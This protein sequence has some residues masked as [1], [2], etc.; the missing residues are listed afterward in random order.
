MSDVQLDATQE[1]TN[2]KLCIL[3]Q[4]DAT[5]KGPMVQHPRIDSF[6]NLLQAV[7]ERA[8]LKDGS[9][10]EIQK[11]LRL[12]T[13]GDLSSHKAGWHRSCYSTA[14]NK[15][16]I[17]RARNRIEDALSSGSYITKKRGIKR[18]S[19]IDEASTSTSVFTRSSTIPL[20]KELC[21][22]CQTD[23]HNQQLFKLRTHNA[24]KA[25]RDALE[26]AQDTALLTRL[27]TS[28]SPCD[29][30][31]IDVRYHKP[32]W[33]KHVFHILRDSDTTRNAE[34]DLSRQM[35]CLIEIIHIVDTHTRN[36]AYLSMA[37]IEITYINMFD[38][39]S[40]D[41]HSPT[42]SRQWLKEKILSELN[43]V[44]SV[45]QKDRRKCAILYSLEACEEEMVHSAMCEDDGMEG[46]KAIYRAAQIVRKS[47]TTF[48]KNDGE[49]GSVLVSSNMDD[50]PCELYTL[51][52]WIM[53]GPVDSLDSKTRECLVDRAVLTSCQTL[54]FGLKS[55]RQVMHKPKSASS[56]KFRSQQRRENSQVLGLALS[57]HHDTRN[58]KIVNLL[59][60]QNCCISYHHTML[61]ETA[62]FNNLYVP[63]FLKK[64]TFVFFAV[65]NTDFAEDTIDGKGTT[66]GTIVAVYQKASA[67][68]ESIAPP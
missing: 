11:R 26:I 31:A 65:D 37:D 46:M 16:E 54:M 23:D 9:Y 35:A 22:F 6:T 8:T 57:V 27:N 15:E 40:L 63:P 47:I 50:I 68:G 25:L 20:C 64:G 32:C 66:H 24:G 5:V 7:E 41:N 59:H 3:C 29:A 62:I 44:R 38:R 21:F 19:A 10:I 49:P 17:R 56:E 42:F 55:D 45:L 33:R 60:A 2:W 36:G 12:C 52:Q 53:V 43:H 1:L 14:T 30:H 61:L 13:Y 67:P 48:T 58:K 34:N 4:T 18:K 39:K 28:L 51:I